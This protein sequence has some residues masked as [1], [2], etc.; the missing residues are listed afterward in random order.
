MYLL[1]LTP[2]GVFAE[3]N[4]DQTIEKWIK[5][6]Q[7]CAL[8]EEEQ[9][10]EL[11]WFRK[12]AES[13][14]GKSIRTTAEDIKT[15]FWERDVLSKAFEE[16]TGIRVDHVIMPEG[17]I[18]RTITEQMMT[19]RVM[20]DAYVNDSDLKGTHLRLNK[21][22]VLSDYMKGEG[23]TYTD[24]YLDLD[25]YLNLEFGQD[26]DGNQLQIADQ[27][28]AN[29]YWFRYD[30]FTDKKNK[31]DFK[32]K[33]GY[34]LGV[35]INWA[36]YE[37][38]AEFFTGRNMTNP[39]G[40]VVKAYGHMDYA[41]PSPSLGWRF[42]DAWLSLAGAGDKGL[43]NGMPVDEWGIRV[44]NK[45]PVGSTV[46]RGGDLDG[47]AAVY[48]LTKYLEWLKFA[49]PEA[50]ELEWSDSGTVPARGDI[51]QMIFQYI[52]WLS[53]DEYHR[54]GSPVVGK[55]GKP[56]WRVA[57]SPHGRYWEEGMK[58]GYQDAGSWTIPSNIRDKHRAMTWLWIQFCISKSV[59]VKKFLVGG[60]PTRK[61]TVFHPYLTAN[62]AE[63]G[64]VIEFYRSPEEKKWTDSGLNVP[65]YPALSG[66]WWINIA[67]AITK[68]K[69]PQQAMTNLAMQQDEVMSKLKLAKFSPKLAEV[70]DRKYWLDQPGAPKQELPEETPKTVP[71]DELIQQWTK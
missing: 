68:E 49:P 35:P 64:G 43:P 40:S 37:D 15:H 22:V 50:K 52:T 32:A 23:K 56:V 17:D 65:H 11:L 42:T 67:S 69:T 9:R 27:Q 19:G 5:E 18:V 12:I 55:D 1:V 31:A 36:A 70:K 10:A 34:E 45:I 14:R 7:P 62:S 26:Y 63:Y 13:F 20:F 48:A 53:D 30:W 44:E 41:K 51:A 59:S 2:I 58:V 39:N 38:I 60:T 66:L 25:D 4:Y 6:F 28:F 33:Y 57:P 24:P 16:I 3:D 21:I 71:Y 47:P 29:L 54:I 8:T 46:E 61:S